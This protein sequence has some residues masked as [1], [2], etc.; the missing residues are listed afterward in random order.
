MR[1]VQAAT[2]VPLHRRVVFELTKKIVRGEIPP[3]RVLTSETQLAEAFGVSRIV[4]REA[5][6]VL[7]E[8][9]LVEVQQGKGTFVTPQRR[10]NPLDPLVLALQEGSDGFYLA[11]AELLEARKIFEVEIAGLAASRISPQTLGAMS[12]LLRKMDS[13]VGDPEAFHRSDV[14]F[15]FLIIRSANNRV[16]AKL[17]E[18]IHNILASGFRLTASLPGVPQ[19]AQT[20]HWAIFRALEAHDPEEA[21]RAMRLHLDEA[22]K[23]LAQVGTWKLDP[24]EHLLD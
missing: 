3:G 6:R 23:D 12:T 10:W 21:R 18:P 9:G 1:R 7:S 11:Q 20:T 4:I 19:K 15:H 14:E 22:A 5:I 8:K 24:A 13:L 17:I 16:L 2:R